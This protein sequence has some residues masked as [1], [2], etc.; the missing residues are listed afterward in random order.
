M[1]FHMTQLRS[2]SS[3][4][5][6]TVIDAASV[7]RDDLA[8]VA[9]AT[10][11]MGHQQSEEFTFSPWGFKREKHTSALLQSKAGSSNHLNLSAAV[12]PSLSCSF[13]SFY[14]RSHPPLPLPRPRP[15]SPKF[16]QFPFRFSARALG[17]GHSSIF[18]L[19]PP[20]NATSS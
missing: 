16:S 17:H 8:R 15:P 18:T 7:G 3:H 2:A 12:Y 6:E 14:Y 1:Y 19:F 10:S 13:Y 9:T 5:A 4:A 20:L 11:V